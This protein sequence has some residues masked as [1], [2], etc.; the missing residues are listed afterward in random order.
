MN[1]NHKISK[2]YRSPFF[3]SLALIIG[4]LSIYIIIQQSLRMTANSPQDSI[5]ENM[6]LLAAKQGISLEP[7]L[8][9]SIDIT[10]EETP[11]VIVYDK[12]GNFLASS[13]VLKGR[14]PVLPKGV[15]ETVKK[16]IKKSFTWEPEGGIRIAAVMKYYSGK[17]SGYILV[18]R[19]LTTVEE[20]E[21]Y[22]KKMVITGM[23]TGVSIQIIIELWKRFVFK[24]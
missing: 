12:D 24:K 22:F 17:Y 4:C 7:I 5:V 11:F 23:I 8:K 18:G 21:D 20:A 3:Y 14:I 13:A 16:S 10:S 6:S 1:I 19:T 2:F 9:Q 15:F